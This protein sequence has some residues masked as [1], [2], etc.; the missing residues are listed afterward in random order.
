MPRTQTTDEAS[1]NQA[2]FNKDKYYVEAYNILYD[3]L[4]DQMMRLGLDD[5]YV[6]N[7]YEKLNELRASLGL[8]LIEP[9]EGDTDD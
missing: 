9:I 7:A 3:F 5:T 2:D 1:T 8:E 6:E 4:D